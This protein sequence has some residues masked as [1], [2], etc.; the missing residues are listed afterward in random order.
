MNAYN[1][2]ITKNVKWKLGF[3]KNFSFNFFFYLFLLK[4]IAIF[5]FSNWQNTTLVSIP[6]KYKYL[7]YTNVFVDYKYCMRFFKAKY[8]LHIFLNF[9]LEWDITVQKAW[10]RVPVHYRQG[11]GLSAC[12]EWLVS[13]HYFPNGFNIHLEIKQEELLFWFFMFVE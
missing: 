10:K 2:Q 7:R 4:V 3:R 9:F 12:V 5:A 6:V 8:F 1:I 13:C 11:G